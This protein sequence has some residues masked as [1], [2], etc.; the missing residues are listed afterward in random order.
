MSNNIKI[1]DFITA[2]I[3]QYYSCTTSQRFSDA[4]QNRLL[5]E[6]RFQKEDK[7]TG[8]FAGIMLFGIIGFTIL[9]TLVLALSS[10]T[11]VIATRTPFLNRFYF[12]LAK[13]TNE[14]VNTVFL[15]E[16]TFLY[17]FLVTVAGMFLFFIMEK[18]L[19]SFQTN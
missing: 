6:L 15:G 10:T 13:I 14:I 8:V 19:M 18:I 9:L 17:Y 7:K 1:D 16:T 12:F 3:K 4:L 5:Q 2:K 11:A